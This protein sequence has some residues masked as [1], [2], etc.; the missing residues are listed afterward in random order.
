MIHSPTA[1]GS[2][3]L[4]EGRL[5]SPLPVLKGWPSGVQELG[6]GR[7]P[8][9]A[10]TMRDPLRNVPVRYKLVFTFLGVC[11]LA[12]GVGGFLVSRSARESLEREI[13]TLLR[14][15]SQF[16][17]RVL[18]GDLR[19]L[20]LRSRDFASDGYIR[21]RFG[22]LSGEAPPP[23]PK[24]VEKALRKHLLENKLPLEPAFLNLALADSSG[25]QLFVAD[26]ADVAWTSTLP[27][28]A[29]GHL[30][31][32]SGLLPS[33][34]EEGPPAIVLGT[35]LSS[36][37]GKRQIGSL[38]VKIHSGVWIAHALASIQAGAEL[39]DSEFRLRLID[40]GGQS[41]DIPRKLITHPVVPIDGQ[42]VQKMVGL[43]VRGPGAARSLV[44][45]GARGIL[46]QNFPVTFNGWS[47]ET[48]LK[49][50]EALRAVSGLQA[51]FLLVGLS[52]TGAACLILLFPMRF[53]ARPIRQLRDAAKNIREGDFSARVPVESRDEIGEL[54]HSFNRMAEAVEEHAEKLEASAQSL[55]QRKNELSKERDRLN[56]VI[57]SMRDGLMV[58]DA[59]GVPE[60]WNAAAEPLR[61]V[62]QNEGRELSAHRNC[63]R[64]N[65][66]LPFEAEG[67]GGDRHPC[68]SCMFEPAAPP[69]SCLLDAGPFVYEIHSSRLSA[70][71]D[72]RSGRVLVARDV[73]DRAQQDEREIHQER[74]AV[75]GEVAAVMAHELNNPL[76]AIN[77]FAQMAAS[78][79]PEDS[80]LRDDITVIE[81]NT[82][83]CTRTIRELLDYATGATP[84]VGP[85]DVHESLSEVASFLRAF[86]ESQDTELE[87]QLEAPDPVVIGDEV[88][89]RQVFVNLVLNAMQ[90]VGEGHVR[91]RTWNDNGHLAV[92]VQDDGPGIPDHV[93]EAVFRPF[94]TT[95]AR[96]SGT[97]LGLST[98]RRIA[99]IQGGGLELVDNRAGHTTF[100][101][102]LLRGH[103]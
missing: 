44:D 79:L 37:D 93:A 58:L 71:A 22:E 2:H 48:S 25:E 42:G 69:R 49:T 6:P 28:E 98:A 86:R 4:G 62:V 55:K 81:R 41:L 7:R 17:A 3:L 33:Q 91:V 73:T 63:E 92:D 96:G 30:D 53:L 68:L 74:L 20:G 75:L 18:D 80:P 38:F 64:A 21:S 36:L 83:T 97:G 101:V 45:A 12:F 82:E 95:K 94:Y 31:W 60:V 8:T 19:A 34:E 70:E 47:L 52:L 16:Y 26:P 1:G 89:L 15:Q 40:R 29:F 35:P 32:S 46:S 77:M 57:H 90:A 88:Q 85:V 87:L 76:A 72:G 27:P 50:E 65:A 56:A 11:L 14:F 43:R 54:S 61:A 23:D 24:A 78:K 5:T 10:A 39:S 66:A 99:E 84:E 67:G 102:R 9:E 103:A 59:D 100:R 13:L 51:K